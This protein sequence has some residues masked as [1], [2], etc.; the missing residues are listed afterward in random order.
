MIP[1]DLPAI[2]QSLAEYAAETC[3]AE[4]VS[5]TW[6]GVD[7]SA[8]RGTL[9]WEGDPCRAK[10]TLRLVTVDSRL[11]VRP[12]LEITVG[13]LVAESSAMP[14]DAVSWT[15]GAALLDQI[16]GE[17]VEPGPWVARIH[18]DAGAP[19]TQAVVDM[20]VDSVAG[21][22]VTLRV[23][24]GALRVSAGGKLLTDGRVGETVRVTN[25]ATGVPMTGTL[26]DKNTVEIR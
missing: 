12:K 13:V 3:E 14:G 10:P 4:S 1:V 26:I 22:P 15:Q 6:L 8:V 11:T 5:V 16:I 20:P 17:P 2:E 19:L 24:R 9:H 23:S 7:P 25:L 21:A 18:L